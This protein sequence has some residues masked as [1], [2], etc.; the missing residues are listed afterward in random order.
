MATEAETGTAPADEDELFA[1]PLE[2]FTAARNALAKALARQGDGD[3]S[4][5]IKSLA[6]PTRTAW[7]LNQVARRQPDDVRRLLEAGE[8]V[9]QAQRRA[10]EGDASQLRPAA[11]A[12]EDRLDALLGAAV[13][14]LGGNP[15]S[16]SASRERMRKTLRAAATDP[17]TGSLLRQGR[18]SADVEVSGFGL[19]DLGDLSDEAPPTPASAGPQ[20]DDRERRRELQR[21]TREA[22]RLRQDAQRAR[23]RATRL[24]EE[25]ARAER[26]AVDAR[27]Q[28]ERAVEAAVEAERAADGAA[29]QAEAA[30]VGNAGPG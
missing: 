18:L 11:Q 6:K 14:L 24:S 22:E 26:Q 15:A 27:R 13:D 17:G 25:A 10:L 9:R 8:G 23:Q 16:Q 3:A 29:A 1:L 21:V 20:D 2:E 12:E 5:R 30:G 28:A 19:D 4:R 7:A